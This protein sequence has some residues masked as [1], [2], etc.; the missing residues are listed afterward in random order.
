M[1]N[2]N[3]RKFIGCPFRNHGRG[4]LDTVSGKPTYDC[5]GL[6]MAIYREYGIELPDFKISCFATKKIRE[7]FEEEVGKW[8]KLET[9][10]APCAV[11]M[12]TRI[13][14]PGMVCHFGVYIG[15][16]KFIHTLRDTASFVS[17]VYDPYWKK[18]I[19]GYYKWK[20]SS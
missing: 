4:E 11:A 10:D 17:T 12:A 1:T 15:H 14:W 20:R 19:K 18:Q 5:Y 2:I 7:Q 13:D 6:F 9:P 3:L 16:G 8:E